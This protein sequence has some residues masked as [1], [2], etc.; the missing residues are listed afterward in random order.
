[1]I[2]CWLVM[3]ERGEHEGEAMACRRYFDFDK[4][5]D[6]THIVT[7]NLNKI[8]DINYYPVETARRSNMRH[9]PIGIGVQAR[10]RTALKPWST[11]HGSKCW[12]GLPCIMQ[13]PGAMIPEAVTALLCVRHCE[14]VLLARC[15]P[16]CSS[17]S[18][19]CTCVLMTRCKPAWP[20]SFEQ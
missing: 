13:S 19:S 5:R 8:I 9:R 18:I 1:M 7:R 2:A 3:L 15:S 20:S 4:L 16:T 10:P 12:I 14:L 17:C 11:L 6:V